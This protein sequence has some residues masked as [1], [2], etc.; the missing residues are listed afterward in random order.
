MF[1]ATIMCQE[2]SGNSYDAGYRWISPDSHDKFFGVELHSIFLQCQTNTKSQ[3][4]GLD[5]VYGLIIILVALDHDC[6]N[7]LND[8]L[9]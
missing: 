2:L 5:S 8:S 9:S 1:V 6:D 7:I 4:L 3:H